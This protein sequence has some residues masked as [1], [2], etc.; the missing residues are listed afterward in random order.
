MYHTAAAALELDRRLQTRNAI[1]ILRL[2][3]CHN[4]VLARRDLLG[5]IHLLRQRR[6]AFFDRT[7]EIDVL[8]CVAEVGGLL[9]DGDEAVFDLQMD[10]AALGDVLAEGAGGCYCEFLATGEDIVSVGFV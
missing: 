9:D 8:D 4:A 7:F 6:L 5:Q 3:V 2:R 10:F 1:L